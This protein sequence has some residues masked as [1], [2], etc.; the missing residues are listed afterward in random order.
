M[1]LEVFTLKVGQNIRGLASK[2]GLGSDATALL[3]P[4]IYVGAPW[5]AGKLSPKLGSGIG[6]MIVGGVTTYAVGAIFNIPGLRGGAVAMV[7]LHLLHS[8]FAN[9]WKSLTGSMPWMYFDGS[10]KTAIAAST[11]TTPQMQ[12]MSSAAINA[13]GELQGLG[14]ADVPV[15]V[16]PGA[17]LVRNTDMNG[18][19]RPFIKYAPLANGVS[20]NLGNCPSY[21]VS[22]DHPMALMDDIYPTFNISP[23][24]KNRFAIMG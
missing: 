23:T 24:A 2:E 5:L 21:N 19:T 4:L 14:A 12:A 10:S 17:M 16:Q 11:G 8:E 7:G 15:E 6:A 22:G 18:R 9:Q 3:A 20:S 1:A 13:S